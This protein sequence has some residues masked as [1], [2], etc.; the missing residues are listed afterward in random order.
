ML[1]RDHQLFI[2]LISLLAGFAL[3]GYAR[4]KE[5]LEETDAVWA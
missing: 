2:L 3:G 1:P 5:S 4:M